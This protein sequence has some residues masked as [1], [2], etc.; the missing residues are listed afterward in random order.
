MARI[1]AFAPFNSKYIKQI[2]PDNPPSSQLFNNP[3]LWPFLR[4]ALGAID[5]SHIHATA[6]AEYREAWRNRKGFISQNCLF[7]CSFNLLFTYILTGWEGSASDARVYESAISD[8]LIVPEGSYLLADAGFPHC[9]ELLVP[10][11]GIRYHLAEWGHAM[12]RYVFFFSTR[13]A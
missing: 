11:R 9:K 3:K 4:W 6:R 13:H 1:F 10:Y 2:S 7:C 8:D 12:L 5:G